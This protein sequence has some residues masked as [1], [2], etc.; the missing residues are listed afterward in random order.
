MTTKKH[1]K[2]RVR[3]R[4]ART[5]EPY[6]TALRNVRRLQEKRMSPEASTRENVIASCSFCGKPNTTVERLVAGPGVHICNECIAL[7]AQILDDA[8]R[9]PSEESTP[10]RSP[11]HDRPSA[12][13]FAMLPGLVLTADRI[14]AEL[15]GWI[16]RL[17]RRGSDWRTIAEAAGMSVEAARRRFEGSPLE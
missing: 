9:T 7:S 1:L 12:E 15:A 17:R 11:Y 6:V 14:E 2:R 4:V 3:S 10:T 8:S 16:N 5:G 13:I